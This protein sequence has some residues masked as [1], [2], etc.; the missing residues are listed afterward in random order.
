MTAP[1]TRR[2]LWLNQATWKD[3]QDRTADE[4]LAPAV[5]LEL[6]LAGYADGTVKVKPPAAPV[7]ES[8]RGRTAVP[9]ADTVF[10]AATTKAEADG[11]QSLSVVC[12]ALLAA[13]V[14]GT[15]SVTVKA[16]GRAAA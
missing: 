6:L 7:R 2:N 12:D 15:A 16:T 8:G 1:R 5:L 10:A 14:K 9:L 11:I 4:L 13:Y 3:F